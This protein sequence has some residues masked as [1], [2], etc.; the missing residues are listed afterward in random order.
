MKEFSQFSK[1]D[2]KLICEA[3]SLH[4]EAI[5]KAMKGD[6]IDNSEAFSK[7]TQNMTYEAKEY[8]I[9]ILK[10]SLPKEHM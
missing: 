2:Q 6:F 4:N 9:E 1:E 3:L 5:T 7:C 10:R 8:M